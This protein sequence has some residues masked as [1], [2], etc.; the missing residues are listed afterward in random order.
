MITP[1]PSS[2]KWYK[3]PR[4]TSAVVF[5]IVSSFR[6]VFVHVQYIFE[7]GTT[8][9]CTRE[10]YSSTVKLKHAAEKKVLSS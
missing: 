6:T 7:N 1:R 10:D 3:Y 9:L 8:A 2:K 4:F 5:G